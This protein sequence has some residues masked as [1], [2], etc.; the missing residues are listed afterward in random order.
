MTAGR[1]TK[2]KLA[3]EYPVLGEDEYIRKIA[4]SLKSDLERIYK[5]GN[6]LRDAHP[7]TIGCVKAEFKV[8]SHLP[9]DLRVGVF[10][11]LRTYPAYIRFSNAA[12]TIQA[13]SR[14][15]VR[16][17]AIKLLGVE[18][19]K[20]L[21]NEKYET[22]QDFLVISTPRFINQ[23]VIDFY[24]TL[25]A[26]RGGP[27]KILGFFFNPFNSHLRVLWNIA[28]SLTKHGNLLE[29]RFWSTTPY[30]FGSRVVKYSAKPHQ[31]Q[32]TKIPKNPSENYL[33]EVMKQYLAGQDAYFD[34]M[35][36]FQTDPRQMPIEDASVTWDEKASPFRKVGTIRIPAQTFDT[37]AQMKIAEN[38]SFTPWHSL[39]EH[40]PLGSIN[41]ARRVVYETIS[42]YRHEINNA[43][44]REPTVEEFYGKSGEAV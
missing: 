5:P 24:G 34:F 6:T 13:D 22:T 31:D 18:G 27:L 42:K 43:P 40:K 12:S 7:K 2:L 26:I 38:L 44:R 33:R 8:E 32:V 11:E 39:P 14:K 3:R 25:Q 16:G 37:Q 10:K 4:E 19:E 21:E 30:Q 17:M 9:E 29:V 15:D 23:N 1:A 41:R 28:R 36:Q 35:V 20:L